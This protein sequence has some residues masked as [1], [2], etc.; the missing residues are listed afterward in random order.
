M[1]LQ[2]NP[3]TGQ[4]DLVNESGG[5]WGYALAE[6]QTVTVQPGQFWLMVGTLTIDG[7]LNLDGRL[8]E[9]D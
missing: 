6:G 5:S 8:V 1:A 2:Y 4:L 9:I 3:I 7:T